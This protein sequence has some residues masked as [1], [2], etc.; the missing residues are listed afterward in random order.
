MVFYWWI[1]ERLWTILRK[2]MVRHV[3]SFWGFNGSEKHTSESDTSTFGDRGDYLGNEIHLRQFTII[4]AT[5]CSRLV[6]MVSEPE[7]W[8]AFA[9]YLEDIANLK[10]SFNS[11]LLIHIPQMQNKMA[12]ILTRSARKQLSFV[13]HMDAG[14]LFGVHSL[15]EYVFSCW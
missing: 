11:S 6:K 4:F 2:R 3:R 13:V 5:D 9:S 15:F 7:E 12:D 14:Y 1:M 8:P 10:R